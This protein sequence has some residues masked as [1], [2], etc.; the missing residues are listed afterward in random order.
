MVGITLEKWNFNVAR[1]QDM[2]AHCT[3][4]HELILFWASL[5]RWEFFPRVLFFP[6]ISST[7]DDF[8]NHCQN[9][10]KKKNERTDGVREVFF[11]VR[12][13]GLQLKLLQCFKKL[14]KKKVQLNLKKTSGNRA[15]NIVKFEIQPRSGR[16]STNQNDE[17]PTDVFLIYHICLYYY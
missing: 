4:F 14:L 8:C 10:R 1:E 2:L 11:M 17:K 15:S 9:K 3:T 12:G 6:L 13:G 5:G 7:F 16:P